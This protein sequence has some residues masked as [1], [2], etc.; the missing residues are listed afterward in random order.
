MRYD[1]FD[2]FPMSRRVAVGLL[3]VTFLLYAFVAA[4]DVR[5]RIG[6]THP[7]IASLFSPPFLNFSARYTTGHVLDY[8]VGMPRQTLINRLEQSFLTGAAD[9]MACGP[10]D[11]S[12][13]AGR[14]ARTIWSREALSSTGLV[15]ADFVRP[16][17]VSL[18]FEID[19][20]VVVAIGVISNRTELL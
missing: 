15:C 9:V 4:T 12:P 6:R 5:D 18:T 11:V 7:R 14:R 16:S 19:Q 3:S 8:T 20:D 13:G 10:Q 2:H 17:R 1:R